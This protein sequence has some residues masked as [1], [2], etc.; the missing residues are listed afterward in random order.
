L[1]A[2]LEEGELIDSQ[3]RAVSFRECLV[4]LTSN[5]G[6]RDVEAAA[7]PVGFAADGLGND[8]R[9]ELADRALRVTFKPEFLGRLDEVVQF[10]P[11]S[12]RVVEQIAG[13]ELADL[14][15]RV[16]AAGQRMT[17]T[18]PVAAWMAQQAGRSAGGARAITQ[19][20]RRE[21]EAPLADHL[22]GV[23]DGER[24][25]F[26]ISIRSGRPRIQREQP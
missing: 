3:G 18:E 10:Q 20:L 15:G 14:A 1:L 16:R 25:W 24:A 26:R 21:V 11:L 8:A 23:T 22:L 17:W 4:I 9:R 13:R 6:A 12:S 5:A 2:L 19:V 7:S